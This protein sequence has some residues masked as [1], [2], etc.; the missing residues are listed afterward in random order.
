M[1]KKALNKAWNTASVEEVLASQL[2]L[3]QFKDRYG[4]CIIPRKQDAAARAIIEHLG[5]E[6]V[7]IEGSKR[8]NLHYFFT[9]ELTDEELAAL[10]D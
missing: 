2:V 8:G 6:F 3:T 1:T 4:V 10:T 5:R 9:P 7:S